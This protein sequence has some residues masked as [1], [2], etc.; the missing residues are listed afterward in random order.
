MFLTR[1]QWALRNS[2]VWRRW[3]LRMTNSEKGLLRLAQLEVQKLLRLKLSSRSELGSRRGR[4]N[5]KIPEYVCS[6]ILT[7]GSWCT[8][9]SYQESL[10]GNCLAK[11]LLIASAILDHDAIIYQRFQAC[12]AFPHFPPPSTWVLSHITLSSLSFEPP[13][14]DT[15]FVVRCRIAYLWRWHWCLVTRGSAIATCMDISMVFG[16]TWLRWGR[17]DFSTYL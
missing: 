14:R 2:H 16:G 10:Q 1:W 12:C 4:K 9:Q 6:A 15:G 11:R 8:R 13:E 5:R 17:I 3:L 7:G